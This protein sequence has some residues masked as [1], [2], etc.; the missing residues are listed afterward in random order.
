MLQVCS[1]YKA[2]SRQP[3]FSKNEFLFS[4][5]FHQYFQGH[6]FSQGFLCAIVVALYFR[7][8]SAVNRKLITF[9]KKNCGFKICA[10][11]SP[12]CDNNFLQKK[13]KTNGVFVPAFSDFCA[14]SRSFADSTLFLVL[15]VSTPYLCA[16]IPPQFNADL[17]FST[18]F[19]ASSLF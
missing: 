8:C 10:A 18:P 19:S 15:V 1:L 11:F 2:C 9:Y 12:V 13:K 7:D 14:Y 16:L 4:A 3:V 17:A 6:T 5:W